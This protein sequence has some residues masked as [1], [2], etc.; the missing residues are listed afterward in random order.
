MTEAEWLKCKGLMPMLK[1][2]RGRVTDRK[3]RLYACACGRRVE[4]LS[5]R[6]HLSSFFG[7]M[8]GRRPAGNRDRRTGGRWVTNEG[9]SDRY[10]SL[11][12]DQHGRTH[13]YTLGR[14]GRCYEASFGSLATWP[15]LHTQPRPSGNC[16]SYSDRPICSVTSS[17]I[18][19]ALPPSSLR[20]APIQPWHSR[21]D[22]RV[23]R[24]R[25]DADPSRRPSRRRVRHRRH[26]HPLP[27]RRAA[28]SR[29]LGYG[30]RVGQGV[31]AER[32]EKFAVTILVC[33][34][35][36]IGDQVKGRMS[37]AGGSEVLS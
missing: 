9:G 16:R 22:V 6:E 36:G 17:A 15:F 3:L 34:V 37:T 11:A 20:G 30:S 28:R 26:P 21:A 32:G 13:R 12:H 18:P 29:V 1:S 27:G 33:A 25:C 31:R 8:Q 5:Y 23:S 24:L 14:E 35:R 10:E 7:R 2:L 4:H 19:S